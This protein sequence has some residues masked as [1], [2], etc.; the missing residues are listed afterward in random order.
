LCNSILLSK[1]IVRIQPPML[2]RE[3]GRVFLP[4]TLFETILHLPLGNELYIKGAGIIL[5]LLSG[6]MTFMGIKWMT[7]SATILFSEILTSEY[8]RINQKLARVDE[9]TDIFF[10]LN[11]D[12]L[13][14]LQK[15]IINLNTKVVIIILIIISFILGSLSAYVT[16][17]ARI[18]FSILAV[19]HLRDNNWFVKFGDIIG[20]QNSVVQILAHIAAFMIV[21]LVLGYILRIFWAIIFSV[22]GSLTILLIVEKFFNMPLGLEVLFDESVPLFVLDSKRPAPLVAISLSIMGLIVQLVASK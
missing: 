21:F 16:L 9:N 8:L 4:Y 10:G 12:V 7:I 20:T 17:M 19:V 1:R 22:A 13:K 3:I 14:T 5:L 2:K 11:I 18:V 6:I 15:Y